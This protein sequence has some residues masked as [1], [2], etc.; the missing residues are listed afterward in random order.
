MNKQTTAAFATANLP[1]TVLLALGPVV[2]VFALQSWADSGAHLVT[3]L[4]VYL[5]VGLLAWSPLPLSLPAVLL[6]N[7][8]DAALHGMRGV[9]GRCVRAA[10]LVPYLLT[11][12]HSEVKVETAASLAGFIT[13]CWWAAPVLLAGFTG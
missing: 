6:A 5:L 7:H 8:R 10:L 4:H 1:L 9:V 3:G 13:A 11:H 2:T 12:P